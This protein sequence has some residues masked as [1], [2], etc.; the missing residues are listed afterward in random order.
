MLML[1]AL[2]RSPCSSATRAADRLRH[3]LERPLRGLWLP[4]AAYALEFSFGALES[5]TAVAARPCGWALPSARNT[6]ML[7]VFLW[8]NRA[9]KAFWV[10][11]ISSLLNFAVIAANGFRM[12]ISPVVHDYPHL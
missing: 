1:A 5:D 3:Y 8:R 12:P 9:R 4:I 11:A 6:R 10:I 2:A 7:F